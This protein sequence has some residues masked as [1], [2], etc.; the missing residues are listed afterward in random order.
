MSMFVAIIV[1]LNIC[2]HLCACTHPIQDMYKYVRLFVKFI[3]MFINLLEL[4]KVLS[5]VCF[6]SL[7]EY[8]HSVNNLLVV[9][10]HLCPTVVRVNSLKVMRT[11]QSKCLLNNIGR[12]GNSLGTRGWNKSYRN[13]T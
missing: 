9:S 1:C 13:V 7:G 4:E 3:H 2:I 12:D 6:S 11:Y 5:D 8:I 10:L